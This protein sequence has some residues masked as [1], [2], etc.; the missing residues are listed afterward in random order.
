MFD[1]PSHSSLKTGYRT[2]IT[3][4]QLDILISKNQAL[5]IRII[6]IIYTVI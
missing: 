3:G 1:G 6:M 5:H 2:S 4:T